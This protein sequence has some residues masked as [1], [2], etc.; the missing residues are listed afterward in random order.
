MTVCSKVTRGSGHC[1]S[2]AAFPALYTTTPDR[3]TQGK[4]TGFPNAGFETT[5]IPETAKEY[6]FIERNNW[7]VVISY[8]KL[9]ECI[10]SV[11]LLWLGVLLCDTP[12]CG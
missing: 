6:V 2:S 5:A 4:S 1:S 9:L 12:L 3:E 11:L 8:I 10:E 7:V